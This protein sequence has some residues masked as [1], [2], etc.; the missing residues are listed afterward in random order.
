MVHDAVGI[1]DV[2][3]IVGK[4]QLLGVGHPQIGLI[5]GLLATPTG[6]LDGSCREIYA[7][8]IGPSFQ[9]F[10][11]VSPHPDSDLEDAK[12]ASALEICEFE[13]EWFQRVASPGMRF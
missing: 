1:D 13:D 12:P 4:G 11:I 10:Q 3:G 7:C 2:E 8:G 9:P 6:P 5:A